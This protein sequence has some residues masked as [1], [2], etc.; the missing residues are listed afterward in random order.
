M[1]RI[2]TT[3]AIISI[4]ASATATSDDLL[5]PPP[6]MEWPDGLPRR[7][8]VDDGWMLPHAL[9]DHIHQRLQYLDD[10]PELCRVKL[11]GLDGVRRAEHEKAVN[12][13]EATARLRVAEARAVGYSFWHLLGGVSAGVGFGL[14]VGL[15]VGFVT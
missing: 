12:V 8:A 13:C 3:L 6:N 11:V 10:F 14:L 9:A 5:D 15:I 2:L 4:S 1:L 7:I